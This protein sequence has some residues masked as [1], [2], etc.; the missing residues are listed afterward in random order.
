MR[1][2]DRSQIDIFLSL[3]TVVVIIFLDRLSKIFFSKLLSAGES[4]PIIKNVFHMTLVHN[5]GIAFGLFKDQ[6]IV[7]IIIPVIAV[8][9]LIFNIFYYKNNK[10]LSRTYIL[11]FSLILGGAIGNLVDRINYGYVIDFI[12]FRF[13]PVFNIA[14]SAIT[15]GA[16]I[17]G[18]KCILLSA[19]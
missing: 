18:I 11:G 15:I 17:I 7:F 5:T 13:W 3:I 4:L 12:D 6:G 1:N 19:K 14:D 16:I 8:I 2:P 10:E 9:L